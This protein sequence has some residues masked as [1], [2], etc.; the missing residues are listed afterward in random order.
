M[1]D[2][3][4]HFENVSFVIKMLFCAQQEIFAKARG[5]SVCWAQMPPALDCHHWELFY[6]CWFVTGWGW[7]CEIGV[8]DEIYGP[9]HTTA[10]FSL[11]VL[12][13]VKLIQEQ[14]GGPWNMKL[15][16]IND[17]SLSTF[18]SFIRRLNFGENI[19]WTFHW[20]FLD[21]RALKTWG[22]IRYGTHLTSNLVA[23]PARCQPSLHL[24]L[25]LIVMSGTPWYFC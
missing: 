23:V 7:Y 14:L 25:N 19:Q 2:N 9:P 16:H 1:W 21:C 4:L 24:T 12:K 18:L 17:S 15:F 3:K 10:Y 5:V 6:V 20:S 8:D 22:I 11:W 13:T